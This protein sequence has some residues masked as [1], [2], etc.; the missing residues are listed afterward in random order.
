[1]LSQVGKGECD[2]VSESKHIKQAELGVGRRRNLR[3]K[4]NEYS[5][6]QGRLGEPSAWGVTDMEHGLQWARLRKETGVDSQCSLST[7]NFQEERR[8]RVRSPVHFPRASRK[9]TR[10]EPE[11]GGRDREKW[12]WRQATMLS[13]DWESPQHSSESSASA[14]EGPPRLVQSR[15]QCRW[16]EEGFLEFSSYRKQTLKL[17]VEIHVGWHMWM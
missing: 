11:A 6:I 10:E 14:D 17:R 9:E 1:M 5:K 13:R 2:A 3:S 15:A 7:R 4:G 16:K 8:E 12:V